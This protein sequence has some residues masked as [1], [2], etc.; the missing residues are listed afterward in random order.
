MVILLMQGLYAI[1][2]LMVAIMSAFIVFHIV[3]FSYS[4]VS[5]AIMLGLFIV[6]AA[7]LFMASLVLF[8][9]INLAEIF[10]SF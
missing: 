10:S 3:R 4:K 7:I 6:P 8:S 2:M 9:N 5:M 1:V